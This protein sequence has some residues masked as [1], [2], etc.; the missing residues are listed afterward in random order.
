MITKRERFNLQLTANEH[1]CNARKELEAAETVFR[2]AGYC[3][4]ADKVFFAR[5]AAEQA[6]MSAGGA[7]AHACRGWSHLDDSGNQAA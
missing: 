4:V 1:L 2:E 6:S 7:H 3:T 5:Q